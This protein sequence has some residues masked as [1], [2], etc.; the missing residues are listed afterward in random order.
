MAR[1][2]CAERLRG[3]FAFAVW[4]VQ[5]EELVLIR[6]RFGIYPLFYAETPDGFAFGSECSSTPAR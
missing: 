4:D 1:S 2:P 3:M 6:D 5:A